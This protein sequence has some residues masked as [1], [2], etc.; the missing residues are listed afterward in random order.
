MLLGLVSFDI[1][2]SDLEEGIEHTI[3]ES[4]GDAK[5][6]GVADPPEGCAAVL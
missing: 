1:F 3:S 6:G 4:A 5:L 2:T